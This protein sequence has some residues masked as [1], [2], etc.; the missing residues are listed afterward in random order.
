MA[1]ILLV[2]AIA[3]A[4]AQTPSAAAQPVT[5]GDPRAVYIVVLNGEKGPEPDF[6]KTGAKQLARWSNR[7]VVELPPAALAA[8]QKHGRVKYVQHLLTG[9]VNASAATGSAQSAPGRMTSMTAG[10]TL[11]W[12]TG[13][14]AYDGNGNVTKT[15]PDVGGYTRRFKYDEIDRLIEA[16]VEAPAAAPG[17]YTNYARYEYDSFGNRVKES[18][19]A[20]VQT[21]TVDRASNHVS[22]MPGSA[23]AYDGVGNMTEG[24]GFSYK[25]DPFNNL[26]EV[27]GDGTVQKMSIY[28]ANDERIIFC[29]NGSSGPCRWTLRGSGNEVLREYESGPITGSS[30]YWSYYLWV[31]DYVYR[32]SQLAGAQREIA[33]GGR[34]HFHLDHLGTARLTTNDSGQKVTE[35]DFAPFGREL[36]SITQEAQLGYDRTET[37]RFTGHERDF[38]TGTSTENEQFVDYMHARTYQPLLGRFLSVDPVLGEPAEPSSWNRYVYAR[39]SPLVYSDPTGEYVDLSQLSR[40]ERDRLINGLNDFTGNTYTVDPKTNRLV[41]VSIGP[42]SSPTATAFVDGLIASPNAYN[43]SAT[44]K[45]G[46]S[47]CNA[48]QNRIEIEFRAFDGA[49]Y[50]GISPSTFNLGSTAIHEWTHQTTGLFDTPDGKTM[51]PMPQDASWTGPVVDAVNI[52]RA[53]RGLPTRAAYYAEPVRPAG[54]L[55][56]FGFGQPRS[57]IRFFDA[58]RGRVVQVIRNVP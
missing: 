17:T 40:D 56:F 8:L 1:A 4:R 44:T 58:Q 39:N 43:V 9:S 28:N 21:L 45:P 53:E 41:L 54:F 23:V 37:H 55:G 51:T 52:M 46:E 15:G 10:G 2:A 36:T 22:S 16:G 49:E 20:T 6:A 24:A 13:D 3:S 34:L 32:G 11:Q 29:G 50:N 57:G 7:V 5:P 35:T 42:N 19:P 47:W 30:S 33:E 48:A 18:T 14:Y 31:E 12:T 38:L 27:D 25:Y 26:K